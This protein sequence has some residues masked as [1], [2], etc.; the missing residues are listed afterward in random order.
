MS[1]IEH[2]ATIDDPRTNVNVKHDFLDILLLTVSAV[3]SDA[4]GRKVIKELGDEKLP[5]FRC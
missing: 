2:F 1:F 4:E 5:W 3:M